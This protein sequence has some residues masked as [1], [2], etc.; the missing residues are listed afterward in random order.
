MSIRE[1]QPSDTLSAAAE[2]I[3]RG[4]DHRREAIGG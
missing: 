3:K 1:G 2:K 4:F